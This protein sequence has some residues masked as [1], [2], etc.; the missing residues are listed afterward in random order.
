MKKLHYVVAMLCL[1][2]WGQAQTVQV[3]IAET[4]YPAIFTDASLSVTNQQ[5][6]AADLTL[7][8]SLASS[9]D[10]LKG[11]LGGEEGVFEPNIDVSMFCLSEWNDGI[12]LIDQGNQKS[13]RVQK[14]ASDLYLRSFA[15]IEAHSNAVRAAHEFVTM[16]N[17]TNLLAQSI[18]VLRNLYHV[19]PLSDIEEEDFTDDEVL[20]RVAERQNYKYPEIS[21]RNFFLQRIPELDDAEV[22]VTCLYMIEKADPSLEKI[23]GIPIDFYK[24]RWGLGRSPLDIQRSE[25]VE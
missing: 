10:R 13:V 18:Q 22:L 6:I 8:F 9:F 17:H 7:V 14:T 3:R 4:N 15:L 5:R 12:L 21:V 24:G 19:A 2:F 16:L 23:Y 11:R 25:I 20:R 1:P